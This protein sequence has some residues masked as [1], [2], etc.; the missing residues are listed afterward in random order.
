[1]ENIN[2]LITANV[3]TFRDELA[4][5][6]T[7]GFR[8]A[9]SRIMVQ[10][11]ADESGHLVDSEF[12]RSIANAIGINLAS[13]MYTNTFHQRL[14]TLADTVY[15]I[16]AMYV[17]EYENRGIFL[18]YE[19]IRQ[20]KAMANSAHGNI[21]QSMNQTAINENILNPVMD[22]LNTHLVSGST[23]SATYNDIKYRITDR[24]ETY[25]APKGYT[26]LQIF[27]RSLNE[28]YNESTGFIWAK[29]VRKASES[30]RRD[31]CAKH[32]FAFTKTYYHK[33]EIKRWPVESNNDWAGM[34]K[35][36]DQDSIFVYAGGY[37][38][39][40]SFEWVSNENIPQ[41]DITRVRNKQVKGEL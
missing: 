33:D 17:E 37:N 18:D 6:G 23:R 20:G 29:Y 12:N 32:D 21:I 28:L 35:G 2:D 24:F 14:T 9:E 16:N 38:C 30:D 13:A 11:E 41:K 7:Y 31:F 15:E 4:K 40:H 34:I 36:T 5:T 8:L 25:L 3:N 26:E 27:S 22:A 39:L 1:M 19:L 10:M